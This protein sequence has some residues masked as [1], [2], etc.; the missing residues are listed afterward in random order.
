MGFLLTFHGE[1]RWLVALVALVTLVKFLLGWLGNRQYQRLDRILLAATTGL[2][3]LNLLL[4]LILLVGLGGGLPGHR[5]EHAVTMLLAIVVM[6]S[7]SRWR[8]SESSMVKFRNGFLTV[9]V[10]LVLV[11]VGVLRLRGG[12]MF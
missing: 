7:S 11:F 12:W 3:D 10:A 5:I 1:M 8:K 2:M 4:G 9:L 6:H